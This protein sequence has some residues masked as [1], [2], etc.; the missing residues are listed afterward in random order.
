MVVSYRFDSCIGVYRG[1]SKFMNEKVRFMD[2]LQPYMEKPVLA[3]FLLGWAEGFPLTL[4]L[5]VLGYWLASVGVDKKTIG[6]FA[7]ISA[8]YALKFLWAPFIDRLP[9]GFITKKYGRR[10]G[11]LFTIQFL[12]TLAIWGMASSNPLEAPFITGLF[13]FAVGFLSAS[14]DT[15]IDAYRIEIMEKH[16]Y[17]HGATA[18]TFGYR[19]AGLTTGA[20]ALFMAAVLPWEFVFT[21]APIMLLPGIIAVLWVGE[22]EDISSDYIQ[23]EDA[24]LEG[25]LINVDIDGNSAIISKWMYEAIILPFKE[26]FLRKGVANAMLLLLFILLFKLGDAVVAIMTAPFLVEM[27]FTLEEIAIANKTVGGIMIWVG[28]FAGSLIYGWL[29]L[30]RSLFITA[31]LMML[32]NL[33]FVYL[34]FAGNDVMALGI[35]IAAENF[36]SGLGNVTIVA[37]LSGLCNRSFTATQYALLSSVSSIGRT[38]IG[39]F[40]GFMADAFGWVDFFLLST[41]ASIP[42]IILLWFLWSRRLGEIPTEKPQ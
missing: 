11:W 40:S 13:A 21:I 6:I 7:L 20:A 22:P 24:K 36:A 9:L 17:G 19:A 15:V 33:A 3:N 26:F 25:I 14:Q 1:Y 41:A 18:L 42:S 34:A 37:F 10:R 31:I 23:Q 35:V 8:P 16:Q 29:G 2:G 32:T 5:G 30:Y 4:I 12:M 38:V 28:V 39:S 27:A